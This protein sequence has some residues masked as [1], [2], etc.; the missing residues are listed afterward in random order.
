MPEFP[1]PA[2]MQDQS[3]HPLDRF[4]AKPIFAASVLFLICLAGILHFDNAPA[5]SEVVN[6]CEWG[7]ALLYP[8]FVLEWIA[9]LVMRSPGWK[10]H[11]LFCL[12][13]PL[14]IGARDHKQGKCVWLPW[15][16]WRERDRPLFNQIE[17]AFSIPMILMALMV[18]PLMFLE[19]SW[20]ARVSE[21]ARDAYHRQ[22]RQSTGAAQAPAAEQQLAAEQV[23]PGTDTHPD[24]AEAATV[25]PAKA[26]AQ[27]RR[28]AANYSPRLAMFIQGA[29]ALIWLAFTLEFIVMISVVE[30]KLR[31]CKQHSIDLAVI[32]LPLAAFLRV[33]RLGRLLRLHQLSKTARM[34]R[35]RGLLMKAWR[36]VLVLEVFD[37]LMRGSAESRLARL[38]ESLEEKEAEVIALRK[39]ICELEDSLS[40]APV[41]RAA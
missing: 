18:L 5:S 1:V 24:E 29:T 2:P 11:L 27:A 6:I 41:R 20:G 25:A 38:R 37:R 32:L 40:D 34:Y 9:H 26:A 7:L 4:L 19:W 12:I 33:A 8:L 22:H 21:E 36:A 31:Y 39:Q 10:Q 16:G 3:V 15:I 35:I 30:H 23:A 28:L 13:P 17:K 14:R